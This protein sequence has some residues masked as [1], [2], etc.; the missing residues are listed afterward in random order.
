METITPPSVHWAKHIN[1]ILVSGGC[2]YRVP[3]NGELQMNHAVDLIEKIVRE[4]RQAN[5]T[6]E[7][8]ARA[9][10]VMAEDWA[11]E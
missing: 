7:S 6:C 2:K 3:T 8:M 4:V 11:A 5:Q 9:N 10:E 1:N